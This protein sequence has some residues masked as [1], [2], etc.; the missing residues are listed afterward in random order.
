MSWA[1]NLLDKWMV[2]VTMTIFALQPLAS[3]LASVLWPADFPEARG[4][5]GSM[6]QDRHFFVQIGW[7]TTGIGC[8][9]GELFCNV[10]HVTDLIK[11]VSLQSSVDVIFKSVPLQT[12]ACCGHY[13]WKRRA[14]PWGSSL[15]LDGRRRGLWI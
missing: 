11:F 1:A 13:L 12:K 9:C 10:S 2:C 4:H 15:H 3:P 5:I 8:N 7:L 14:S 6:L